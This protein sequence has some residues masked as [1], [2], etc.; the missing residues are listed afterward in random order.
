[1]RIGLTSGDVVVGKIGDDL[2]MDYTAQG[3]TVALAARVEE[4]APPG[5]ALAS[6]HTARW[7]EGY[8]ELEDLGPRELRGFPDPVRVFALR[9]EGALHTRLD[10]ARSRGLRPLVGRTHELGRLESALTRAIAGEGQAVALVGDAG[11]GK[12]R[13]MLEFASRC[14][15]Q[16]T[17]VYEAHCPAHGRT[18][19]L[20]AVS[21]LL[22]AY[23]AI[24][25][26]D[27]PARARE[28][29]EGRLRALSPAFERMLPVVFDALQVAEESTRAAQ[30]DRGERE[31]HLREFLRR[32]VQA[33]SADAPLVLLLDDLH[34]IDPES[35]ELLGDLVEALGWTRTL[36]VANF[37]PEHGAGWLRGSH[38]SLVQLAPLA[39]QER[40]A[41]VEGLLG[42]HPSLA[43]LAERID[44]RA[45]G[46]PLFAE[47]I[48]RAAAASGQLHGAPG[49]YRLA[50]A[51]AELEIEIPETIQAV[52]AGRIDRLAEREKRVLGTAAVLGARFDRAL[53]E[54]VL[55]LPEREVGES[56]DVLTA[57]ELVE[58]LDSGL[59]FR[60][61]LTH[62]VAYL[63]QLESSRH[64][65]HVEVAR[66]LETL[67]QDRLGEI[68]DLIAHHWEAAGVRQQAA[69]WRHRA[70]LRVARI[71][72]PRRRDERR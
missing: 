28:R 14:R 36:L 57:L 61:P 56:L 40:K 43:K 9:S 49:A 4:I 51:D 6:E 42:E 65:L 41:L 35:D 29:I 48:V 68:A 46:N 72:L 63:S 15:A 71:Q 16:G 26:S 19:P 30:P 39:A 70:A 12:S 50:H 17:D 7:V 23:F 21:S 27:V 60:H 67:H 18:L 5:Q 33:A 37:R 38:A 44:A 3:H 2:R 8:F 47:E 31:H 58:P 13:L 64:R 59:A 62:E 24:A 25:P 54:H 11:V 53:L 22:R 55:Q 20:H 69:R 32:F 10:V 45:A 34:W 1:V 52:L 66:A